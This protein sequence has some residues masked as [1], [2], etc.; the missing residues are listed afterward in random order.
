M[1]AKYLFS[2]PKLKTIEKNLKHLS[3]KLI[4]TLEDSE[5]KEQK[6][7]LVIVDNVLVK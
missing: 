4:N 3:G 6:S 5:N 1:I 7:F 2:L